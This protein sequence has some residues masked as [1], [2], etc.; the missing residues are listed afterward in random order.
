[1]QLDYH[2]T[3]PMFTSCFIFKSDALS[4]LIAKAVTIKNPLSP[5]VVIKH[6]SAQ[7]SPSTSALFFHSFFLIYNVRGISS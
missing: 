5:I 1:M 4:F 6:K 7:K 3:N 2:H